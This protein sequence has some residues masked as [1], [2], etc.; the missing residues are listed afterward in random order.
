MFAV[1]IGLIYYADRS[2]Y[3]SDFISDFVEIILS[4]LYLLLLIISVV[5]SFNE[6]KKRKKRIVFLPIFIGILII[7]FV[8]IVKRDIYQ[9]FNKS[10]LIKVYYDGDYNGVSVDFKQDGTY[11]I[12]NYVIG[13]NE[14]EY[15]NYT[16]KDDSI[17][18]KANEIGLQKLVFQKKADQIFLIDN[19][20]AF[21]EFR[22]VEDNRKK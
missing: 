21:L 11:I 10:S 19:D 6:Y 17:F 1:G 16:I 14:Y 8:F 12:N 4:I 2:W 15:G 22:I 20:K 9:E 3:R 13:F 5:W 18:L 7:S